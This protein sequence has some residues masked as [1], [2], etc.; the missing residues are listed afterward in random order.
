M[1]ERTLVMN[2]WKEEKQKKRGA[3]KYSGNLEWPDFFEFSLRDRM[4]ALWRTQATEPVCLCAYL[5]VQRGSRLA[6]KQRPAL[7]RT[8]TQR[9]STVVVFFFACFF[10]YSCLLKH[11]IFFVFFSS[12][13][14]LSCFVVEGW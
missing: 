9:W 7:F 3:T 11:Y 6:N 1:N 10:L 8:S 5:F 14:F 4:F 13:F 2:E 12:F